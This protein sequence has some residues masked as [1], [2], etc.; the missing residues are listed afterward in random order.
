MDLGN[1]FLANQFLKRVPE[2]SF[3]TEDSDWGFVTTGTET[4]SP[5]KKVKKESESSLLEATK[6]FWYTGKLSLMSSFYN[7]YQRCTSA[8]YLMYN[9]S[10]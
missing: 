7:L 9:S 4:K 1:G 2:D 6:S 5:E 10:L 3:E 8:F